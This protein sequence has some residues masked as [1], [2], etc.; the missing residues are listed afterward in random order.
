M[1]KVK[2]GEDL[3][4]LKVEDVVAMDTMGKT[5]TQTRKKKREKRIRN[6]IDHIKL[7]FVR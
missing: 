7:R 4:R 3:E 5:I 1:R 2:A 6:M